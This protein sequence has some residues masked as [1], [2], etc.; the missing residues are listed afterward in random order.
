MFLHMIT[1]TNLVQQETRRLRQSDWI[2][3]SISMLLQEGIDAVQVTRLAKYLGVSRGSFYWHFEDRQTLLDAM[4]IVWHDQNSGA[5]THALSK[6]SSLSEGVLAFFSLWV[7]SARFNPTLE[8]SVRDWARLDKNIMATV[9]KEDSARISQLSALFKKFNFTSDEASVR[10]R[11]LYYAQIG[12]YALQIKEPM[13]D[14]LALLPL[15]YK[16]AT[17]REIDKKQLQSFIYTY[18]EYR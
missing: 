7:N 1:K 4:I 3:A 6:A 8:Q 17:G 10:A 18:G 16:T 2:D 11:V 9:N 5:L 12:Y 15:Y 13:K 14:R